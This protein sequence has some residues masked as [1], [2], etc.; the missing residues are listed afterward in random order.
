MVN[1]VVWNINR[2]QRALE[3]LL[4]MD[5]D[6]ALLQEVHVGGWEWLAER[7]AGVEVT[8]HEPWLP[9]EKTAYNRW[10]LVVKLSDRVKV[11]WFRNR[12]PAHWPA[13][14][15]F[16]VS[17]IGTIAVAKVTPTAGQEPFIAASMY[18]RLRQPHPSVGDKDWI[19]SDASAHRIISDLS[20]FIS[21]R[22][23]STHRILAAGDMN[24][25][26]V[27]RAEPNARVDTLLARTTAL[28]LEYIGPRTP[29]GRS[30]PTFY[31][32]SQNSSTASRPLDHVFASNGFHQRINAWAMNG[33][34]EWGP[35]DHCR[36][37]VELSGA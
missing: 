19:H 21:P 34:D 10:P 37:L 5:A 22:E 2:N 7:G 1:V 18:S 29:D 26:L 30:V 9:W 11:D 12:G 16:P 20:V 28:G 31:T 4:D 33:A 6:L 15:E 8:P 13:A 36:I 35:S 23:G 25:R 17:G 14:H 32:S 27:D 3:Q 24:M